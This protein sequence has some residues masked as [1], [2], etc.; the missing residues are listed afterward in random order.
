MRISLP[1]PAP[2]CSRPSHE[3]VS[4][5]RSTRKSCV[6]KPVVPTTAPSTSTASSM[7]H[8][9]GESSARQRQ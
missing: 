4:K 7:V 8:F 1:M 5:V 9:A 6:I 3:P 2:W